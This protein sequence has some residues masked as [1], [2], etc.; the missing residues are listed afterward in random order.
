[1]RIWLD[2][3]RTPPDD[4]W[5]WLKTIEAVK[6]LMC[7]GAV[8]VASLDNDLGEGLEEGRRLVLWMAE[9]RIWPN[10][11]IRVHSANPVACQYMAGMIARYSGMRRVRA[12]GV[13][14]FR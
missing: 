10:K 11:E 8:D 9:S 12:C 13:P 2:D 1:M 4:S 5:T 7:E 14:T 6:S 3:E